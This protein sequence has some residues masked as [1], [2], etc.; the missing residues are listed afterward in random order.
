MDVKVRVVAVPVNVLYTEVGVGLPLPQA[1]I[2]VVNL[3]ITGEPLSPYQDPGGL[4]LLCERAARVTARPCQVL[5]RNGPRHDRCYC[6]STFNYMIH[7]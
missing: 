2:N 6:V 7:T 5:C 4:L 3:W 1:R